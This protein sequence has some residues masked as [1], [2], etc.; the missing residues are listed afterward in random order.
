MGSKQKLHEM[1]SFLPIQY[2]HLPGLVSLS[3]IKKLPVTAAADFSARSA[4]F[5]VNWPKYQ[6]LDT[7][8][9]HEYFILIN[10]PKYQLLD[11]IKEWVNISFWST[12]Q[13][14]KYTLLNNQR[15]NE[16]FILMIWPKY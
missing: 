14:N 16:Y 3:L 5:L 15:T 12:D 1:S 7:I 13:S 9:E 8:N 4:S 10:W 11:R 2:L 6:L